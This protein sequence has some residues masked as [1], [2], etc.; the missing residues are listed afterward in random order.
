MI[1]DWIATIHPDDVPTNGTND[2]GVP[3][4][5]IRPL[6]LTFCGFDTP[7]ARGGH[8]NMSPSELD[9]W[10]THECA[11]KKSLE[12]QQVR[13]RVRKAAT[14]HPQQWES[15]GD[16]GN[17]DPTTMG[18]VEIAKKV[19]AFNARGYGSW[20]AYGEYKSFGTTTCPSGW[21]IANLNWQQDPQRLYATEY[22]DV[23]TAARDRY[24]EIRRELQE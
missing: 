16:K 20:K 10:G 21:G 19:N 17:D 9:S 14:T 15:Y 4:S 6:W 5:Q 23:H 7:S 12:P 22:Y 8:V 13:D 2:A 18:H 3:W 11:D 24:V 1:D